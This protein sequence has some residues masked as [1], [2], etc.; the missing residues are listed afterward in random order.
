VR[1]GRAMATVI[2]HKIPRPEVMSRE[3][4][5]RFFDEQARALVGLSGDEFLRRWDA[6]EY[7]DVADDPAHAQM[8]YLAMLIPF[9]R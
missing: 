7:A 9:G 4:A 6:G 2:K 3:E 8:M 5:R 1:R